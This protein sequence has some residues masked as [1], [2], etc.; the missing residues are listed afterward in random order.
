MRPHLTLSYHSL[1]R[2]ASSTTTHF[3]L[4]WYTGDFNNEIKL[5]SSRQTSG[6]INKIWQCGSFNAS[7]AWETYP[8][9]SS[10]RIFHLNRPSPDHK[11]SQAGK[12]KAVL[13]GNVQ[14]SSKTAS[15]D[16]AISHN[17]KLVR[18]TREDDRLV[19]VKGILC[20]GEFLTGLSSYWT[21]S[22]DCRLAKDDLS[23]STSWEQWG[24]TPLRTL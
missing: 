19:R 15:G 8:I 4:F 2:W 13:A 1:I 16:W 11:G 22:W 6:W 9:F 5:S 20:C 3:T 24:R 7:I 18:G 17:P 10:T 23:G 14:G 21:W 12:E